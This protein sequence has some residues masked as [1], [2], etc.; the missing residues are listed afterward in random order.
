MLTIITIT[1]NDLT[2]LKRTILSTQKLRISYGIT[3]IVIDSSNIDI[4]Q[5]VNDY[6]QGEINIKSYYQEA[7]GISFAFNYGVNVSNNGWLWFLNSGDEIH[8][9]LDLDLF[10]KIINISTAD[11]IFFRIEFINLEKPKDTFLSNQPSFLKIWLPIYDWHTH[12]G[13]LIQRSKILECGKFDTKLKIAMDTDIWFKAF[14]RDYKVDLIPLVIAKFYM[15]GI[16]SNA[17][18]TYRELD[19]IMG[20]YFFVAIKIL[21]N[22]FIGLLREWIFYKRT[23]R[24][25]KS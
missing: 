5:N 3:Q 1:K 8:S 18:E 23:R 15:G 6:I 24:W 25:F 4:H 2:G 20:K 12:P 22:K 13:S 9:D 7:K 10:M 19:I 11:I 16:S 21:I 14:T 17:L